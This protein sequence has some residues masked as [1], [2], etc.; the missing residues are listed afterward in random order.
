MHYD[1]KKLVI[2]WIGVS[3]IRTILVVWWIWL[4]LFLMY[5]YGWSGMDWRDFL[6]PVTWMTG[7]MFALELARRKFELKEAPG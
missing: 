6:L 3:L 7:I 5:A 4:G 2:D 1:L